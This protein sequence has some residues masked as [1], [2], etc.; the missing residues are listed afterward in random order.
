MYN[1]EKILKWIILILTGIGLILV[2]YE[3]YQ[4][5]SIKRLEK[6]IAA[7]KPAFEKKHPE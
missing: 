6:R 1:V 2:A 5:F 4:K 7:N 3:C